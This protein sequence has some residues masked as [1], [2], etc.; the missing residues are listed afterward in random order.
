MKIIKSSIKYVACF[1]LIATVASCGK[2]FL[3]LAPADLLTEETFF[4]TESDAQNSLNGVY[5]ALQSEQSFDNV[6]DAADIEWQ[7]SGDLYGMDGN[8]DR[9]TIASLILPP[10]NTIIRDVYQSAY[11]GIGRANITIERVSAMKD[12]DAGVKSLIIG[13]AKFLR[14]LFYYRLVN[15]FGGVPLVLTELNASSKLEIPR[16]SA[17]E[18]W[19]QVESDFKDA[20]ANLP[21][22][23]SSPSDVGR[24]TKLAALG[25]L[26]KANLWQQKWSEAVKNSEDINSA[27][28]NDLLPNYRDVFRETN[29]NNKEILFSTQYRAG[30]DGEGNN[31]STRSAPRGAPSQFT[32]GTAWSNF[33]PQ[34]HWVAASEKDQNGRI[35]DQRY[36]STIIGPGEAHQDMPDFVMPI[37]VPAGWSKTGYIVTKYWQ[38]ANLNAQGVNPPIL[39]YA[40]VLL[41]Y[42]EA[43]NEVGRSEEAMGLVNR[44]RI[45]AGLDSKPL[46]LAKDKV[47]DAIYNE[48]RME[49]I[50]EPGGAFSD[51]NRRGRFID[52]IKANRPDFESLNTASKPWLQNNPIRLPIPREAWDNNKSLIQNPG[53][54]F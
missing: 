3:T 47:L 51:L 22:V 11:Q 31:L 7:M 13:Q 36:W 32:G 50:W 25:F 37:K 23:W 28:V 19:K 24:A 44:I 14:G 40:E 12:L 10:S 54:T 34:I 21:A 1:F 43:L 45:R 33:V 46:D 29:E 4:I 27:N 17:E 48:R 42:A 18:V 38:K 6:R 53:Y 30:T 35:K 8:L 20:A 9:V 39:R 41:N 2:D 52:F 26:V 5:A 16:S 49:F 15:Y